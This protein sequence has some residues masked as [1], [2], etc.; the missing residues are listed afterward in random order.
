MSNIQNTLWDLIS[1]LSKNNVEFVICGGVACFLHGVDRATFDLDIS[2]SINADNINRLIETANSLNL[3]PRIPEPIENLLEPEKRY[4]WINQK[5]ALVYT[6]LMP[7]SIVQ[8]DIFLKYP[9]SFEELLENAV[10]MNIKGLTLAVS[11]KE[12]LIFAKSLVQPMRKKDIDD[13]SELK[14]IIDNE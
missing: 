8:L 10:I 1:S 14:R 6:L 2:I 4:E 11:S 3:K 7:D 12:D 5:G 9:K 13:I